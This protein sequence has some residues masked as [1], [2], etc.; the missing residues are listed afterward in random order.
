MSDTIISVERLS[1]KYRLGEIGVRS[2]A[3]TEQTLVVAYDDS[4][5]AFAA[6]L[7]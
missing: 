7:W 2:G 5:L 3:E 4:R 6:R 1:K